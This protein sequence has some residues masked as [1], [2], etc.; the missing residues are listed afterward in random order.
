MA[1]NDDLW[2]LWTKLAPPWKT[3][4]SR[5]GLKRVSRKTLASDLQ[6]KLHID[7][8]LPGLEDLAR[9]TARAV[10]PGDPARSLLYHVL[11]S[12]R[13]NPS[14]LK[15]QKGYPSL[16]QIELV[17]NY[18]YSRSRP[19][20]ADL[21]ARAGTAPL[22]IVVFA[23]E[24]SPATETAHKRHADLCFSRTGI[25]RVGTVPPN[26]SGPARGFTPEAP[27]PSAAKSHA[28]APQPDS[29]VAV[30][31]CRYAAFIAAQLHGDKDSIRPADFQ[32][33]D[34]KRLFWVPL[35]KLFDGDECL[36]DV[37]GLRVD[38]TCCHV[39]QKIKKIHEALAKEGH[40]T[41]IPHDLLARP[42][43]TITDRIAGL[44][45]GT[46]GNALLTPEHDKPLIH[47]SHNADGSVATFP[48]PAGHKAFQA[49]LWFPNDNDARHWPEF[50][51]IRYRVETQDGEPAIVKAPASSN[52]A[53]D[54]VPPGNF[55]AVHLTDYT[56]DGW[57]K[58]TV[59]ALA[60]HISKSLAAYSIVAQPDFFPFIRQRDLADWWANAAPSD[61]KNCIFPDG[62][63]AGSLASLRLPAN[64]H[65]EHSGF[66]LD[67]DTITTILTAFRPALGTQTPLLPFVV[68]REST[69]PFHSTDVFQPGWDVGRDRLDGK[70]HLAAYGLGSPFAE[71]SMICAAGGSYW[72]AASPD[73]AR[74]FAPGGN[75]IVTPMLD[76]EIGNPGYEWDTSPRPRVLEPGLL[77]YHLV[78][79]AD[80]VDAIQEGK[81]RFSVLLNVT[82]DEYIART[83]VMAR[84]FQYL[85][86]RDSSMRTGWGVLTFTKQLGNLPDG[87]SLP[88]DLGYKVQIFLRTAWTYRDNTTQADIAYENL[89]TFYATPAVVY[90]D[91]RLVWK[92]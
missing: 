31:P 89:R 64:I 34:D 42:P 50:V 77:R 22:A 48:V 7:F 71:D 28:R 82:L 39:N 56:A 10:E 17:E 18:V 78:G 13:V 38:F 21:R 9:E 15:N 79:L 20:L 75:I 60:P 44:Q 33:G 40:D 85:K 55:D 58:A 72:P 45:T 92:L 86:V 61:I 87:V 59:G 76:E 80:W 52:A 1:L 67:D 49:T 3:Y 65:L 25:A 68:R 53:A 2:N 14:G 46:H 36:Q 19:S 90:E 37:K 88:P 35:H 81:Q 29:N 32:D 83:L 41:G 47:P 57:I 11:A 30:I 27:P 84:I 26:Y 23:L 51:N 66:R 12:P 63:D 54:V 16:S 69:L 4:L 6:A 5:A 8:S 91:N 43:Y 24:Y 62:V 70:M 74:M 73:T